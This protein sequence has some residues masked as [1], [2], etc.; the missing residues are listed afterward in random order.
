M[1][2]LIGL[3]TLVIVGGNAK[4]IPL[5]GVTLPYISAGGSSMVSMMGAAGLLLGIS[6]INAHDEL[7]DYQRLADM[8]A[9]P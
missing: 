6:S 2:A 8:E 7:D 4:L 1:V 3:Q 5:T 9:E